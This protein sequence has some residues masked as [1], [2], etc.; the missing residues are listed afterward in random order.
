MSTILGGLASVPTA[1]PSANRA[2][3][4]FFI[5]H[6]IDT[7]FKPRAGATQMNIATFSSANH[8]R[9]VLLM[10][11]LAIDV[12]ATC[13]ADAAGT[14]AYV[15]VIRDRTDF[16]QVKIG[17]AGYWF[18]Q[19]AANDPVAGR[20]TGENA[21]DALPAWISPLNH[22]TSIFDPAFKTRT[23][24]QD[25]PA[26]SMGGIA[27]WNQFKLPGGES[28]RS[29]EIVD[30]YARKNTN[31]TI[32]RIQLRNEVPAKFYFHVVTDNT[33]QEYDPTIRLRARGNTNGVDIEATSSP[34]VED[35]EFNGI[36]DVYT[37]RCDGFKAGDFLKLRLSALRPAKAGRALVECCSIPTLSRSQRRKS[38]LDLPAIAGPRSD[39]PT[40]TQRL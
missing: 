9:I 3:A 34:G 14:I 17:K 37:F 27:K 28:G 4:K 31:N 5:K 38:K 13:D 30:P 22:A 12:A 19:F 23:F 35:L 6:M 20:P 39:V 26:R 18:P 40:A 11:T 24:S 10:A 25:G 8:M 21:R 36:A 1:K 2:L 15:G 16:D 33:N 32:N 29:G 7:Q